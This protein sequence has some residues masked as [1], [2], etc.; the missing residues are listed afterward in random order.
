MNVHAKILCITLLVAGPLL[1]REST[2]VIVMKNGDRIT[3]EVKGLNGGVLYVS[4]LTSWAQSRLI[5]RKWSAWK[6]SSCS[7]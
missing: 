5:G 3:C 1:A 4:P 6:A 2:D 7:S